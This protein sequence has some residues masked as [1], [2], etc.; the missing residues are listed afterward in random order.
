[1]NQYNKK[2]LSK[3]F[4]IFGILLAILPITFL[5]LIPM[6]VDTLF[7]SKVNSCFDDHFLF[8]N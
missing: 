7:R 8:Q 5:V 4:L 3:L 6:K 1:M 2:N